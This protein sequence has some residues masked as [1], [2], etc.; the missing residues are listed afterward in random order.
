MPINIAA[1]LHCRLPLGGA[2]SSNGGF[3]VFPGATFTPDPTATPDPLPKGAYDRAVGKW[4]PVDIQEVSPDGT[5]YAFAIPPGMPP[6]SDNKVHV[7]DAATGLDRTFPATHPWSVVDY[8]TDGVYLHESTVNGA[9]VSNGLWRLD[10]STGRVDE[11]AAKGD[12]KG[13]ANG[14]AWGIDPPGDYR[15]ASPS[16]NNRVVRLDLRTRQQSTYVQNPNATYAWLGFGTDSQPILAMSDASG[17]NLV[18]HQKI[19][20]TWRANDDARP[21]TAW[22]D[23]NG[24]WF[25]SFAGVLWFFNDKRGLFRVT[26]LAGPDAYMHVAGACA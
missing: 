26:T 19:I 3:L 2:A 24:T 6:A 8:G 5:H 23:A 14:V 21:S 12:W 10:P 15:S 17:Y 4:L 22:S 18:I 7:V 9:Y 16:P 1:S 20:G 13:E 25:T 11:L